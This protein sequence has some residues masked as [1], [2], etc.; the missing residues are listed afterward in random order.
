MSQIE[1]QVYFDYL[2]ISIDYIGN[3]LHSKIL[4]SKN[5]KYNNYRT[6]HTV[7]QLLFA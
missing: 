7:L 2:H 1:L 4:C 3:F 5:H 6:L